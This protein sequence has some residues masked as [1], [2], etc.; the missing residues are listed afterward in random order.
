VIEQLI[1]GLLQAHEWDICGCR[2]GISAKAQGDYYEHVADILVSVLG[3]RV[4]TE[5]PHVTRVRRRF[6]TDWTPL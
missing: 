3:L 4:E 2:C 5:A 6:V 1:A